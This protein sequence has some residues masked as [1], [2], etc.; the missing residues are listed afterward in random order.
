[1]PPQERFT[2][3]DWGRCIACLLVVLYHA[4][5]TA[6]MNKYFGHHPLSDAMTVSYIRMPFFF[7]MS[8]FLLSWFY[9][10]RKEDAAAGSARSFLVKRAVRI[11]PLYWIA[12][13]L[14]AASHFA[15]KNT[16]AVP[17]GWD[18]VQ[19]VMLLPQ[20]TDEVAGAVGAVGGAQAM[21]IYP[22]WVLLYELAAFVILALAIWQPR[23]RQFYLFAFPVFFLLWHD[24]DI[25]WLQFLGSKWL[26]IIW[27]GA[28]AAQIGRGLQL[29]YVHAALPLALLWLA[30]CALAQYAFAR[31]G[32]SDMEGIVVWYGVGFAVLMVAMSRFRSQ[33]VG[34]DSGG[35]GWAVGKIAL[36]SYAIFLLHAPVISLVCKVLKS[37]GMNGHSGWAVA[38][39]VS[40]FGS[41]AIG[42]VA[43]HLLEAP[44][45]RALTRGLKARGT[46][47]PS[48]G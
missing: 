15:L 30:G 46:L 28:V 21:M 22:V 35:V 16:D 48:K 25:F 4:T 2:F 32:D 42:G 5:G 23:L 20:Q 39:S 18:L 33:V 10:T 47:V 45:H 26:L 19:S 37:V 7:A 11:Y 17:E 24:S 3:L 29:R 40:I 34:G 9:L 38:V 43:Y 13:A 6:S 31:Q 36:W 44:I 1:M 12:F 8:G 27:F 41:I 14:V